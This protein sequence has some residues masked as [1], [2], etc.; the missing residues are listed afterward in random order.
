M[1]WSVNL[2]S[3]KFLLACKVAPVPEVV[4]QALQYR[5]YSRK[6]IN[7]SC[8]PSIH[9]PVPQGNDGRL[10]TVGDAQFGE[11]RADIIADGAF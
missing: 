5:P 9:Q 2:P 11:Y 10:G 3:H 7:G 1:Q 4:S 6:F 8:L